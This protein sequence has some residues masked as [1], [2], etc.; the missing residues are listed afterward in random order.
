MFERIQILKKKNRVFVFEITFLFA[1][2]LQVFAVQLNNLKYVLGKVM[3]RR[4][5]TVMI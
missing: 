3:E 2:S 1:V 4:I 5:Y